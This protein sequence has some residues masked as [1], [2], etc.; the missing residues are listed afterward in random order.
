MGRKKKRGPFRLTNAYGENIRVPGLGRVYKD[1]HVDIDPEFWDGLDWTDREDEGRLYVPKA[2]E[3]LYKLKDAPQW[4]R[5]DA[6]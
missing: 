6:G 2:G 3:M 4:Q 1:D 5:S